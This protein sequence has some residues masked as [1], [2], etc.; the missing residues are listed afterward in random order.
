MQ[1][2]TLSPVV[3][4]SLQLYSFVFLLIFVLRMQ[5]VSCVKVYR[6]DAFFVVLMDLYCCGNLTN[7]IRI[8]IIAGCRRT[9]DGWT[10]VMP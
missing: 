9:R 7:M 8:L 4:L 2:W 1:S 3:A 5:F 6:G 10:R